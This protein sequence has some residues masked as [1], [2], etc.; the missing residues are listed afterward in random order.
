[1]AAASTHWFATFGGKLE[2]DRLERARLSPQFDGT[3]FVN[4]IRPG[5]WFPEHL[6]DDPTQFFG[7]EERVPRRPL[8]VV[9][10]SAT[11]YGLPPPS[12]LRA[13]WIGHASTL[14]EID[15]HRLLTDPIFSER[16]SPST[17]VGPKRFHPPPIRSRRCRPSR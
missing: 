1:M 4:P 13:T 16:A 15:G 5:C 3:K 2:G 7:K 10:R 6:G 12:G 14:V 11:D 8:P 9:P 17:L